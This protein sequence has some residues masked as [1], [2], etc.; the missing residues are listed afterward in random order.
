MVLLRRSPGVE[1]LIQ[2]G[3]IRKESV[4]YSASPISRSLPALVENP[5]NACPSPDEFESHLSGLVE[6]PAATK[7]YIGEKQRP[8]LTRRLMAV[9]AHVCERTGCLRIF[10]S[11]KLF[12]PSLREFQ[13]ADAQGAGK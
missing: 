11:S 9:Y 6:L 4:L 10:P 2:L 7:P 1:F 13:A 12:L 3:S 5:L 8:D